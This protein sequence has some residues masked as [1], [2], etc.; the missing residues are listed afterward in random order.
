MGGTECTLITVNNIL[1]SAI[2]RGIALAFFAGALPFLFFAGAYARENK[3]P[4]DTTR[5]LSLLDD[6]RQ[7]I[8]F[9]YNAQ[10][11]IQTTYIWRGLYAGGMN[12]QASANV[13][14]GGLYLDMWWNVG[15][16][17]WSFNTFQPE[18]DLSLGFARWGLDIFVLYI[19]NF[20]CGFFDFSNYAD[21]GNRLELNA[22]YTVS[23]KLPISFLWATRV[24][25]ADGYI[26][27]Q[28]QLKQA[29]SSYA[30]LS[31]THAMPYDLSLYGAV[32]ITPWRSCYTGYQRQ[33]GVVNVELR[34]RKDWTLSEHCG[35]M[36]QGQLSINPSALA[37]D[38]HTAEWHPKNPGSQSV[39]TNITLGVY[40]R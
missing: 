10:A 36:L 38:K 25:A 16:T 33:F 8:G 19:H 29:Y 4:E 9:T 31:Y 30:E 28:G 3:Q 27:E 37:A 21:R 6:Y 24:G 26:D 14:Y 35:M 1:C 34:L 32:G 22:R 11:R 23:S 17:D 2:K 12:M 7:P 15:V 13:G 5:Q 39:N 40:L 18:V 20:N